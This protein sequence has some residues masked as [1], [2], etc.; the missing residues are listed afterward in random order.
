MGLQGK[1]PLT[2]FIFYIFLKLLA[3]LV[4]ENELSCAEKLLDKV[5]KEITVKT[6]NFLTVFILR[7][8]L[9]FIKIKIFKAKWAITLC[10]T[11]RVN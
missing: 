7:L 2:F 1:S 4:W 8:R 5:L 9:Q 10:G 11:T 6:R 3:I